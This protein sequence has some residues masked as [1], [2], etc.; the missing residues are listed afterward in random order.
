M[1]ERLLKLIQNE[2]LT[3]SKFADIIG[4]QRSNISHIFSGRSNPGMD[5][6]NKVLTSFPNISGDW[7]ITGQGSMLK[8]PVNSLKSPSLFD[9]MGVVQENKEI[10]VTHN[11]I[12]SSTPP[13]S[14]DKLE[15]EN[16]ND[17]NID[18]NQL[19]VLQ[20]LTGASEIDQIVIF[21]KDKTFTSYRP[22]FS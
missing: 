5:F 4:V 20:T 22:S 8:R 13:K 11:D 7:L 15:S 12:P 19:K 17:S 21:Y 2:G 14:A 18:N 1:K 3:P 10:S 9:S 6:L 16:L